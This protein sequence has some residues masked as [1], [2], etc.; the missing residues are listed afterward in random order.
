LRDIAGTLSLHDDAARPSRTGVG[1]LN[2]GSRTSSS[3]KRIAVRN[4]FV[5][6]STVVPA[7]EKRLPAQAGTYT[8]RKE[9]VGAGHE[10]GGFAKRTTSFCQPAMVPGLGR[11]SLLPVAGMTVL[12]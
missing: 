9:M 3:R 7:I 11:E 5:A 12:G 2:G 1:N 8:E 4:I 10:F 6:L